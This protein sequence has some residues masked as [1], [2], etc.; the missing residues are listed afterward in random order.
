MLTVVEDEQELSRPEVSLEPLGERLLAR[1]PEA[2]R[3]RERGDQEPR[4][5]EGREIDEADALRKLGAQPGRDLDSKPGL[6]DATPTRQR[7]QTGR[8]KEPPDFR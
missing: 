4:V 6:P 5:C 7:Q 1:V 3:V 8:G 2:E